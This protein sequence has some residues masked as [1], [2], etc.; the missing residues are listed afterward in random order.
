[1]TEKTERVIFGDFKTYVATSE[2]EVPGTFNISTL[3]KHTV[4]KKP[5][6]WL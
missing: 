4:A 3:S 1:M 5:K 2:K 6:K